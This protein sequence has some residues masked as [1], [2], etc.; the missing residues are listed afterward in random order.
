M[1]AL[2]AEPQSPVRQRSLGPRSLGLPGT[3]RTADRRDS[4]TT[5]IRATVDA[6]LRVLLAEQATAGHADE[7]E[8]VHQMRVAGRRMRVALRMDRGEIGPDAGGLRAELAWLGALLGGVRD[9]DVLTDRLARSGADL[10]ESDRPPFDEVLTLLL[11]QRTAAAG[12]LV[13]GLRRQRYRTL[14]RGLAAVAVGPADPAQPPKAH[15]LL[16]KPVRAVHAQLDVATRKP[17]DDNWHE[18]RIRVK[19]VRYAAELASELAGPRRRAGIMALAKQAKSLQELLGDFQDTVVTE[20]HLRA[21]VADHGDAL[22]P[23]AVM[24]V[25]RLVERQ[26]TKRAALRT[27][28]PSAS[29]AL[30]RATTEY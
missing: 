17:S 8:S 24:I 16:V 30:R 4:L 27:R 15:S 25:G 9:L 3:A 11:A 6:G 2:S 26:I 21:L 10:P 13:D 5:H 28:L 23:P 1:V 20:Q 12:T 19:R 29:A 7:P 14:L 22:S 18:L